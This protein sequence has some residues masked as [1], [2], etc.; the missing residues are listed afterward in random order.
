MME[1][2]AGRGGLARGPVPCGEVRGLAGPVRHVKA[3]VANCAL[4]GE[5]NITGII[6]H[7][8]G[9]NSAAWGI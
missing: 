8:Q 6:S 3:K 1:V 7:H 5:Q 4:M 2:A 9:A